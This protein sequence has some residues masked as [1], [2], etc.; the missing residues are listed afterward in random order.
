MAR[1][2]WVV[3]GTLLT[4]KNERGRKF[5]LVAAEKNISWEIGG[6]QHVTRSTGN[7]EK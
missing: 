6:G 3:C 4:Q 5:V 1:G 2:T 7:V